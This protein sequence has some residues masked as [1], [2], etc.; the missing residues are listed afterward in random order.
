MSEQRDSRTASPFTCPTCGGGLLERQ[1]GA[2]AYGCHNGHTFTA[3]EL[4]EKQRGV[5]AT[6]LWGA[7]R[8]LRE[9]ADLCRTVAK[10]ARGQSREPAVGTLT[11]KA[12]ETE[13]AAGIIGGLVVRD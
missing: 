1:R 6:A 11:E 4:E 12:K 5:V 7:L 13:R 9:H 8:G 3:D 10:H 2:L